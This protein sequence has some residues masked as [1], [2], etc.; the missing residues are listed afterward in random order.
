MDMCRKERLTI[1]I[2]RVIGQSVKDGDL[3]RSGEELLTYK[4]IE[5]DSA[6]KCD[7]D[8]VTGVN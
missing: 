8:C 3:E 1:F 5:A 2:N 7:A 4:N 6:E